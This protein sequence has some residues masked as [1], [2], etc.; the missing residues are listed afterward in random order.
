MNT[1]LT[2]HRTHN[3]IARADSSY[4]LGVMDKGKNA[5]YIASSLSQQKQQSGGGGRVIVVRCFFPR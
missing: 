1:A 5:S 3:I 4:G 2:E